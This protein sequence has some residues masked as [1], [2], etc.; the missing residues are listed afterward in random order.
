M[1]QLLHIICISD[2]I[3]ICIA[4]GM[5]FLLGGVLTLFLSFLQS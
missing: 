4:R 2:V 1:M 3:Y 5:F